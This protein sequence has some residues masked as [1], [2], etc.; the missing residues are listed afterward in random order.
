MNPVRLL[1]NP[2]LQALAIKTLKTLNPTLDTPFPGLFTL[3]ISDI[4][5]LGPLADRMLL[6]RLLPLLEV[7]RVE[8][9]EASPLFCI[10]AHGTYGS[11]FTEGPS[12]VQNHEGSARGCFGG[13]GLYHPKK[14]E[15]KP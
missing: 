5:P 6:E 1:H 10:P 9:V 4:E 2:V 12:T 8:V 15:S 7:F 11:S 3:C 13:F 14:T